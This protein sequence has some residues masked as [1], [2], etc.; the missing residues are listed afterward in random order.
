[1][2]EQLTIVI[3]YIGMLAI[4]FIA[5][6]GWKKTYGEI[7]TYLNKC[8]E[9]TEK[10]QEQIG[11]TIEAKKAHSETLK[12]QQL[13]LER[14]GKQMTWAEGLIRQLPADHDG[15]NTWLLNHGTSTAPT[16]IEQSRK[17]VDECSTVISMNREEPAKAVELKISRIESKN[18][19]KLGMCIIEHLVVN[20]ENYNGLELDEVTGYMKDLTSILMEYEEKTFKISKAPRNSVFINVN[21]KEMAVKKYLKMY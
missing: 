5:L 19:Y 9:L 2:N 7:I 8:L 15:R 20:K 16:P 11:K 17:I 21:G 12:T 10:L 13:S 3:M 14:I 1:M 18:T 4:T 6:R